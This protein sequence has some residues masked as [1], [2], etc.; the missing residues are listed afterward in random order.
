MGV[1]LEKKWGRP[2]LKIWAYVGIPQ[3]LRPLCPPCVEGM[4]HLQQH[5]PPTFGYYAEFALD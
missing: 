4:A 3:K 2:L 1:V 5:A